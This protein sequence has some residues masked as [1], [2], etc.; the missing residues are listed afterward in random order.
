MIGTS[1]IHIRDTCFLAGINFPHNYNFKIFNYFINIPVI[2]TSTLPELPA[3]TSKLAVLF[4]E[5]RLRP[6]PLTVTLLESTISISYGDPVICTYFIENILNLY[7]LYITYRFENIRNN[8]F[9]DTGFWFL[10]LH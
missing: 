10:I 3:C 4:T 5:T 9:N 8:I 7:E 2:S 1:I 6:S